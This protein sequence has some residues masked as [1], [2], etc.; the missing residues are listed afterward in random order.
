MKVFLK[1][2][3]IKKFLIVLVTIVM[4]SN[5]I[6]P[7]YVC[8]TETKKENEKKDSPGW[9]LVS[10]FF[11]LIAYVGDEGMKI[12]QDFMMGTNDIRDGD[13]YN[14]KYSPGIIFSN[15]VPALDINFISP[16]NSTHYEITNQMSGAGYEGAAQVLS[17]LTLQDFGT[18]PIEVYEQF[19]KAPPE[20]VKEKYGF[21]A[22]DAMYYSNAT[23][24][25]MGAR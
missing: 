20:E 7:N 9:Q 10:G 2:V 17:Q 4:V 22:L 14:I 24:S 1:N 15:I 13:G 25:V 16:M 19:S 21:Y 3:I 5:F 8:A 18:A 11:Y 12:M 6:M 23:E